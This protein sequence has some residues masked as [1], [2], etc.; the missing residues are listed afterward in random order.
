MK[1][2]FTFFTASCLGTLVALGLIVLVFFGIG[3]SSMSQ[4]NKIDSGSFLTLDLNRAIPERTKN[5]NESGF[6]FDQPEAVG[7]HDIS[8]LI[9]KAKDDSRI[10]GIL[11]Y[12]SGLSASISDCYN[13]L[14]ALKAFKEGDKPLYAYGDFYSQA[15]YLISSVADTIVLNP[16]GSVDVKGF[17]TITPY[18]KDMFDKLGI[19]MNVFYA[20]EFK[21]GSE[22]FRR[23]EMSEKNRYQTKVFLDELYQNFLTELSDN[24]NVDRSD[25]HEG[26]KSIHYRYAENA[27]A[28]KLVDL[29]QYKDEFHDLVRARFDIKPKRKL[30]TIDIESYREKAGLPKSGSSKNKIAVVYAEGEIL[31]NNEDNG[32]ISEKKYI[33]LLRKVRLDENVKALV[34]R[35]DS[36][37][38]NGYSSEQIWHS[39]EQFKEDSIPVIASYGNYA[40]SGGYYISCGADKIISEPNTLTGSIG[41]FGIFPNFNGLLEEK[42]GIHHDTVQTT[43]YA[44]AFSTVLDLRKGEQEV[45][46][47]S[48][49]RMYEQF[50]GRVAEGRGMTTEAVHEVAKGRVWTGTQAV[51]K[52]LVDE[53]GYLEDAINEAAAMAGLE[54]YKIVEYPRIKENEFMKAVKQIAKSQD[55]SLSTPAL[56]SLEKHWLTK[57]TSFRNLVDNPHPQ[58]RI[59]WE[60]KF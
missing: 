36:P 20:G 5:V 23:T 58:M 29:L 40:A 35:V 27:Q 15:D 25:L 8:A 52:G 37:G 57:Y 45:I 9:R 39:I 42:L 48:I 3:A 7:I 10:K 44:A 55:A 51:E 54:D 12:S 56:N 1:Q 17:R 43:D 50:L 6:N 18:Y 31:Y 4:Q 60:L 41:V 2:F 53:L 16:K 14:D 59:P 26:I 46:Q 13:L 33:P 28:D 11:L 24:R 38:G 21:G 47:E 32:I 22:P 34:L 30:K 49:E 19:E